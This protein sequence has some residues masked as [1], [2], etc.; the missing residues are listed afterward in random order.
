MRRAIHKS[1]NALTL[2]SSRLP[3]L[4]AALSSRG[5]SFTIRFCTTDGVSRRLG[6]I[7]IGLSEIFVD[8]GWVNRVDS[9]FLP[10]G[11]LG[12]LG[13][14]FWSPVF[15]YDRSVLLSHANGLRSARVWR[16]VRGCGTDLEVS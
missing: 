1:R 14:G 11:T 3:A 7:I 10:V 2:P 6:T 8:V 5:V 16:R 4:L 13:R 15:A 12:L 9:G